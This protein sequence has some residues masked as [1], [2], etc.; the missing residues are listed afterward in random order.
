MLSCQHDILIF[1]ILHNNGEAFIYIMLKEKGYIKGS[2]WE[3]ERFIFI[4]VEKVNKK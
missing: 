3:N 1:V 4:T 2:E